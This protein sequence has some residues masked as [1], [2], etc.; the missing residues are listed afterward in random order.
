[1]DGG[2]MDGRIMDD[3]GSGIFSLEDFILGCP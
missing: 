2:M 1:M 3:L